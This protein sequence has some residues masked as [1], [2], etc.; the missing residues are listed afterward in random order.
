MLNK[1]LIDYIK[2]ARSAHVQEY[3]IRQALLEAGWNK[4][5][6]D[7]ALDSEMA[8]PPQARVDFIS[9]TGETP[10]VLPKSKNSREIKGRLKIFAGTL[11]IALLLG[12]AL[13]V[14]LYYSQP[15]YEITLPTNDQNNP[16]FQFG[17]WP[18]LENAD[19]FQKVKA[20]FVESN[21]DFIEGD[22]SGMKLRVYLSG[23]LEKEVSILSKGREGS[24]W[25][26]PAGLYKIESREQ[27]HLSS[28][29]QVYM[30]W[31]MAFQGNFYIHG[32]PYYP[33]GEPVAA[34]YSGG[35]IRLST[36]DAKSIYNLAR[37]EM[38]VLVFESGFERDGFTYEILGNQM[39]TDNFLGADLKNNFIFA[40]KSS[41]EQVPIASLTK[42]M[43][44]IVATE[45]INIEKATIITS[46]MLVATSKPRLW[47]GQKVTVLDLLYPLLTESSNEAAVAI[48]KL[49]GT[50]KFV[51]LMNEKAQAIGMKS[52]RFT[53]VTGSSPENISTAQDLFQLAKYLYNNRTF[54]LTISRGDI[55][56]SAYNP[57]P[58]DDLENFNIFPEDPDFVGGKV[59]KTSAAGETSLSI[60]EIER[61]GYRRPVVIIILG[62]ENSAADAI[63]LIDFVRGSY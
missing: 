45:Y 47:A 23:R 16:S 17:S 29:G 5:E 4:G 28:F 20:Q 7:D 60:F 58:W 37:A 53:D 25:E 56:R 8:W 26:T 44:A 49:L 39:N 61:G 38:P 22:L 32:W 30:P 14:F 40:E 36:E 24:W 1:T 63:S 35:C 31:S 12:V 18:A 48:A 57:P 54:V 27:N 13:W 10:I 6:V 55:E 43:T 3:F 42:L 11:S 21:T 51:T 50:E 19:F 52:T 59:G 34:G 41:T 2:A 9:K 33:S 15:P 62:S 46:G